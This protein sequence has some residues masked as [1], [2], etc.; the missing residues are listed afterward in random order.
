MKKSNVKV[1]PIIFRQGPRVYLRPVSREDLP[2]MQ[3]WVN[4]PEVTYFLSQRYPMTSEGEVA[5]YEG[6]AARKNTDVV[7]AIVLRRN[8]KIIGTMG[9]HHI[10][11]I[12][13]LAVTGSVIGEK[14]CWGKGYG[15]EAKMLLLD[16]AFNT[17]N[18]RKICSAVLGFNG[19]SKRC[20]EKC[21]YKVE[22]VREK[23]FYKNGAYVDEI[24]LAVFKED[25]LPLWKKFEK[26]SKKKA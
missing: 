7:L 10:D 22:A 26:S 8:N 9:L 13:G 24:L 1:P 2:Q 4:D 25:F 21:G 11:H 23:H 15:T 18:L 17:L 5:W 12:N 20:L 14:S 6:L 3:T 19:R 16:Y